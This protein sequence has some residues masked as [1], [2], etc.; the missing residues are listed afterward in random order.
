VHIPWTIEHAQAAAPKSQSAQ[1]PPVG[2]EASPD[3]HAPS[4]SHH[5]QPLV[6][7]QLP[8]VVSDAHG[9]G[10]THSERSHDQLPQLP[11]SGP[12]DE[13]SEHVPVSPHQPQGNSPVH[14]SQ[15]AWVE[16]VDPPHSLRSHDQ[17]PHEPPS[18]P[19]LDP[20]WQLPAPSPHQP[21]LPRPVHSSQSAASAHGSGAP[22]HSEPSHA[23]S[24]QLPESGPVEL[25]VVHPAPGHQP[26]G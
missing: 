22:G 10:P 23:Q 7:A 14:A 9:S 1:L 19:E 25:P 5:P 21:Q 11:L 8:H 17:S 4:L 24:P 2:P 13:P 20:C 12:V 6:D 26:H 3:A 16:Q 15:S 18:G